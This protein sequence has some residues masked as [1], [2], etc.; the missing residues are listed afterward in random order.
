MAQILRGVN[1]S[2]WLAD[3]EEMPWIGQG[4]FPSEAFQDLETS[5][6][7]L[8]VYLVT[9]ETP[10]DKVITALASK[11]SNVSVY[12]Y[13]VIDEQVLKQAGFALEA[14]MGETPDRDVNKYHLHIY[15]LTA[16]KLWRLAEILNGD[17]HRDRVRL[18]RMRELLL[19]ALRT[20][21]LDTTI[22]NQDLLRRLSA[23]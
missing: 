23:S 21:V 15:R 10:I 20:N 14:T 16:Q 18:P 9:D 17:G 4:E 7:C 3:V 13:I 6:G 2:R 19:D 8:S 22:M 1:R 5:K 11:R 12:D